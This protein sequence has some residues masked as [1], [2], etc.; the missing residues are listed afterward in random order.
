LVDLAEIALSLAERFLDKDQRKSADMQS[1]ILNWDHMIVKYGDTVYTQ[2]TGSPKPKAHVL[3]SANFTNNT[4][5]PQTYAL[6]TERRTRS[7]CTVNFQK[8]F[9]Y[10]A[11]LSIKIAPPNPIIEANTGFKSE[12]TKERGVSETFEQELSWSVDNQV[13]VPPGFETKAELVIN[14]KSYNGD[15]EELVTFEGK[16]LVTFEDK[17]TREHIQTVKLEVNKLFTAA[18]GFGKDNKGRPTF[19]VKGTC[20]SRFGVE[21]NVK[22]TEREIVAGGKEEEEEEEEAA[23]QDVEEEGQEEG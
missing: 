13:K 2:P 9:T 7:E 6:R 8:S 19:T 12:I 1:P 11:E 17:K 4:P 20:R 16:V 21:Q 15:F 22:L 14:E 5:S 23:A 10:G 18:S 3:F